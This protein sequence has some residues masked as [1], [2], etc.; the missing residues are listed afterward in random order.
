[1]RCVICGI[2]GFSPEQPTLCAGQHQFGTD[3]WGEGNR[4]WCDALHRGITR[5]YTPMTPSEREAFLQPSI[6]F[7][8]SSVE[9]EA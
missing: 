4:L 1:M 9:V 5:S 6:L 7:Q 3:D 8:L 2:G